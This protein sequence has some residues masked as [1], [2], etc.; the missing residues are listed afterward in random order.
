MRVVHHFKTKGVLWPAYQQGARAG[1][2][3]FGPLEHSRVLGFCTTPAT[4]ELSSSARPA[5]AGAHRGTTRYRRLKLRVVGV[6]ANMH[7]GY[8]S[9]EEFEANRQAARYASG[10]GEDRRKTPL[11]K[12]PLFYR[13]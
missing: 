3:V 10:Y 4:Q 5:S 12:A 6:P 1:E 2:L 8:I 7:P 13:V 9:W 11:A